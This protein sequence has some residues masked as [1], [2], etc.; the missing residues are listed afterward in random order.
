MQAEADAEAI[1]LK[2]QAEADA[3][4]LKKLAEAEGELRMAEVTKALKSA[5]TQNIVNLKQSGVDDATVAQYILRDE[6]KLIAE[7]D[8]KKFEHVQTGNVTVVGDASTAGDFMLNTVK[9]ISELSSVKGLIPGLPG[10]F[11]KL[12]QFDDKNTKT[13]EFP[14]VENKD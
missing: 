3:I 12:N 10:L 5:E 8:A 4:R 13:E 6:Y 11:G 1:R 2:A 7:A 9:K 14:P